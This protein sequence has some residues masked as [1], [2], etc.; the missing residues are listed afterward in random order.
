MEIINF[1]LNI[2]ANQDSLFRII[3]II[4]IALYGLFALILFIQ[5]R[6]LNR[7]VNQV[8]FSP[9]FIVLAF[10]H[11]TITLALLFFTVLFLL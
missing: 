6:N 9:V 2:L 7:I 8:T 1:F 11:L 3:L 5:I 4:L 10:V